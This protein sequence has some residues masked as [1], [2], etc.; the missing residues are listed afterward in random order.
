MPERMSVGAKGKVDLRD[1]ASEGVPVGAAPLVPGDAAWRRVH[2]I[3]VRPHAR[4]HGLLLPKEQEGQV[5]VG[6]LQLPHPGMFNHTL[7]NIR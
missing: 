4:Q 7:L 6:D 2:V 1:A 5:L 3:T